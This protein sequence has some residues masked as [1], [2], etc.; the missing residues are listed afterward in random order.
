MDKYTLAASI[1]VGLFSE[2]GTVQEALEYAEQLIASIPDGGA[3]SAGR[4]AMHVVLNSV[5]KQ[6]EALPD[7]LAAPPA[8]VRISP[9]DNPATGASDLEAM[10]IRLIDARIAQSPSLGDRIDHLVDRAI[11]TRAITEV[12]D[13]VVEGKVTEGIDDFIANQLDDKIE[14]WVENNLD[15]ADIVRDELVNNISLEISVN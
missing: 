13:Q 4:T 3:R 14:E 12:I 8:E 15:F 10:I 2:R 1:R 9:E 11:D 7:P 6:I 5:A